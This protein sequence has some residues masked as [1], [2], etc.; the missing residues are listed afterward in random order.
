MYRLHCNSKHSKNIN[1]NL[2]CFTN[3]DMKTMEIFSVYCL[4]A[5]LTIIQ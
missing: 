2:L 1:L 4:D 5:D 3:T